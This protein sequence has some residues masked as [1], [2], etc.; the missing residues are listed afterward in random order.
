MD[1]YRT[2]HGLPDLDRLFAREPGPFA[3]REPGPD[4]ADS[5]IQWFAPKNPA[6]YGADPATMRVD[7]SADEHAL[8][9]ALRTWNEAEAKHNRAQDAASDATRDADDARDDLHAARRAYTDALEDILD[10]DDDS[11]C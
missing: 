5:G 9:L 7:I 2:G 4:P 3:P 11:Y 1:T 10:D 8:L 6:D